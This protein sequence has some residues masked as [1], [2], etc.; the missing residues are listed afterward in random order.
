MSRTKKPDLQRVK[1][2]ASEGSVRVLLLFLHIHENN[3][4]FT[5][6]LLDLVMSEDSIYSKQDKNL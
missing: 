2:C 6:G 5:S 1:C 4:Q 3:C